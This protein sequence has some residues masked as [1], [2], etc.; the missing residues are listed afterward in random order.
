MSIKNLLALPFLMSI[1]ACVSNTNNDT[2]SP[3]SSPLSGAAPNSIRLSAGQ[4]QVV[5]TNEE[6]LA[7]DIN[8]SAVGA[9]IEI[10][11]GAFEGI[12]AT[13]QEPVAGFKTL[14]IAGGEGFDAGDYEL[15][16]SDNWNI[17]FKGEVNKGDAAPSFRS[18][19][20]DGG[21]VRTFYEE[22]EVGTTTVKNFYSFIELGNQSL[23]AQAKATEIGSQDAVTLSVDRDFDREFS[24]P[25]AVGTFVYTGPTDVFIARTPDDEPFRAEGIMFVDFE[26]GTGS[27]RADR[28]INSTGPLV[29]D[30]LVPNLTV[31]VVNGTFSGTGDADLRGDIIGI[32][33][34]G[35]FT[36][37]ADG[38]AGYI[39]PNED[40]DLEGGIF[41]L[42]ENPS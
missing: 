30:M 38:V 32:S 33:T 23:E 7:I 16:S 12:V 2:S 9:R 20:S 5:N 10:A 1:T 27:F 19:F 29:L 26:R 4:T 11:G 39:V 6:A 25:P 42:V 17:F 36:P 41:V 14:S 21:L 22:T 8:N 40:S 13:V 37:D 3:L 24:P 35:A 31:D 28:F 15:I 34:E 18:D